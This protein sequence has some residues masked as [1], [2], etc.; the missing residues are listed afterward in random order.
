MLDPATLYASPNALAAHYS[1]FKVSERLLLSGHSHQAWPDCGFDGQ[2]QAWL[3][4]AEY[5]DGKWEHAFARADAVR[6]GF[7]RLLDDGGT[8]HV[9]LSESTHDLVVRWL[10]ALPLDKRPRLVT[11]D[12][13]FHTLR[14]LTDRL[15][16]D[17]RIEVMRVAADPGDDI[18]SRLQTK[19]WIPLGAVEC[20]QLRERILAA[21]TSERAAQ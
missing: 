5:V 1:R 12:G 4:A 2:Q 10:S 3:D 18:A 19:Q 13:E 6:R 21:G 17:G 9:A 7:A 15:E 11:T 16:E 20:E 8:G 14:R